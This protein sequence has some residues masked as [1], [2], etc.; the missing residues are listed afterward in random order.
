M[1][2]IRPG[3]PDSAAD[4]L[5]LRITPFFIPQ[6]FTRQVPHTTVTSGIPTSVRSSSPASGN[7]HQSTW[8]DFWMRSDCC[9][10]R[11]SC[12]LRPFLS[13]LLSGVCKFYFSK[14]N[15][16]SVISKFLREYLIDIY[17]RRIQGL[18]NSSIFPYINPGEP[19]SEA[20]T[21]KFK[22]SP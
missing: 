18:I 11:L 1:P 2:T 3:T 6:P 5:A 10:F 7:V 12:F 8:R 19:S 22:S 4:L 15:A 9:L 20:G 17:D 16:I 13:S 21:P 14:S